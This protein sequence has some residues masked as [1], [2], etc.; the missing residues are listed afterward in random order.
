MESMWIRL[1]FALLLAHLVGDFF[2]Q[3]DSL[4]SFLSLHSGTCLSGPGLW[5]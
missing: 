5:L 4:Q 1:F 3:T 2:L